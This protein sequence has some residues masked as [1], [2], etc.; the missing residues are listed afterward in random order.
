MKPVYVPRSIRP[1]VALAES[2]LDADAHLFALRS[3]IDITTKP[4]RV[5]AV[6]FGR[7]GWKIP[8]S[9]QLSESIRAFTES[10]RVL[11]PDAVPRMELL[12]ASKLH[13][14][15]PFRR[16]AWS[17]FIATIVTTLVTIVIFLLRGFLQ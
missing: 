15:S 8:D 16:I 3:T 12:L 7:Y 4:L 11:W 6:V 17:Y 14:S 10:G 2:A 5:T 13:N 9:N 1:P